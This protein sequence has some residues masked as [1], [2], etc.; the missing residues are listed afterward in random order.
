MAPPPP[1]PPPPPPSGKAIEK[2][3]S[4]AEVNSV[5]PSTKPFIPP[6]SV[7]VYTI[8]SLQQY[9]NSFSQETLIG[10]GTLG[11]VYRA[12]LPNRKV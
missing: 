12:R 5:K 10:G 7:K 2:P 9:T 11:S 4:L 6:T 3:I 1:P 8:A